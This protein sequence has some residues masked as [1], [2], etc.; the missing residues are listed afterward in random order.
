MA[1]LRK[2][3]DGPLGDPEVLQVVLDSDTLVAKSGRCGNRRTRAH[4]GIEDNTS[5]ERKR[6]PNDLTYESLGFQ[7]RMSGN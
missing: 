5:T 2:P 6:G 3:R 7:S 4:E 1:E